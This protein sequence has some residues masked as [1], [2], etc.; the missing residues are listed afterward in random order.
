MPEV[1]SPAITRP[2]MSIAD[3]FASPQMREPSSKTKKKPKKVH[4]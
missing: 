3:E 4:C 2:T 1:P